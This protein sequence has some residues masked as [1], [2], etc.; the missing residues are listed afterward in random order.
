MCSRI[1]PG[2]D[3][4]GR[5]DLRVL[6]LAPAGRDAA[7]AREVLDQAGLPWHACR[8][9]G[10]VTEE[11]DRGAGALLLAEEALGASTLPVLAAAVRRQP[12]WSDVPIVL[13]TSAATTGALG[14]AALR[15]LEP[16]GNVTALERPV[17]IAILLSAVRAA[18]RARRRQYDVR[19]HLE[20]RQRH[21][22]ERER[23]R[24][25]EQAARADVEAANRARDD[26]LAVLSHELRTPLQS[27]LGWVRVLRTGRLEPR[28][29]DHALEA[30]E[31]NTRVQ[32][33]LIEDLLDVSQIV[34]GTLR[35]APRPIALGPVLEAALDAVRSTA[36]HKQILL[37][38]G[39]ESSPI[40]L[41][42]DAGRLQQVAWNLLSNAVKFT[43]E[44]GRIEVRLR[45]AG[46][47]AVVT[48]AD[49][50][51]GI[52][53]QMLPCIFDRFHQ[54]GAGPSGVGGG[55]GLGLIIVRHLVQLHDGT[56]EAHSAGTGR[57]AT[58]TVRLPLL[59]ADGTSSSATSRCPARTATPG[60]AGC[61]PASRPPPRGCPCSPSPPTP[62]ART[63]SAPGARDS[64]AISPSPPTLPTWSWKSPAS[65]DPSDRAPEA[66]PP[67][68]TRPVRPR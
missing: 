26:F 64:T 40:I 56:V 11:L 22:D 57:G 42:G 12:S 52:P 45:R 49:T 14:P 63:S 10:E 16:L 5:A 43:P 8:D 30:I 61:G 48:V 60:A 25:A 44:G 31:R 4:R 15:P 46:G 36:A 66:P 23:L 21:A 34:A 29:G 38:I 20:E 9:L 67:L 37:D 68:P 35:V 41:S 6:V 24:A 39:L 47:H 33:Q 32:T 7:L 50:G 59:P 58:F 13:L 1:G 17:G 18:L 62:A 2:P 27:V 54:A 19:H 53:A 65:S 55:L 51:R 3:D 28:Q